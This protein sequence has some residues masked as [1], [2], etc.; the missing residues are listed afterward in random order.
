M[1]DSYWM[2]A[3]TTKVIKMLRARQLAAEG[4]ARGLANLADQMEA[5]RLQALARITPLA[6][7][8]PG[9]FGDPA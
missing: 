5:F 9:L 4:K 1:S 2:G 3:R 7:Q 6:K 8:F